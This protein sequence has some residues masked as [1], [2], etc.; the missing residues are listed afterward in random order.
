MKK[1][2]WLFIVRGLLLVIGIGTKIFMDK[3]EGINM[4]SNQNL[5][6][7]Q[8]QL[9]LYIAQNFESVKEIEFENAYEVKKMEHA[10]GYK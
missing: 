4:N 10:I 7:K 6:I 1:V 5:L 8:E 9:A 2:K 3:N